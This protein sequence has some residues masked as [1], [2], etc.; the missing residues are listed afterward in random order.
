ME[1][2]TRM[3]LTRG[4]RGIGSYTVTFEVKSYRRRAVARDSRVSV[5]TENA[6]P[7]KAALVA[8]MDRREGYHC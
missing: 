8:A 1:V 4:A 5:N 2:E 3:K 6:R 7:A